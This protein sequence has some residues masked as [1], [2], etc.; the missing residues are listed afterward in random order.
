MGILAVVVATPLPDTGSTALLSF[1]K[2]CIAALLVVLFVIDLKTMLLPDLFV[3]LLSVAALAFIL[4]GYQLPLTRYELINTLGGA[5]LGAGFLLL[6]WGI[7]RGNGVGLGD[8]KLMIPL[9]ALFGMVSTGVLLWLA[10]MVGGVWALFLL[11]TKR[12]QLKTAVPFGPF[13][14]G[15]ALLVLAVP[16]LP[17][18]LITLL[19]GYNPWM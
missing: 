9:G 14:C 10:Y 7:T 19:L 3:G 18:R 11:L 5:A 16:T 13:L 6:I 1:L 2:L 8:V 15:A 17:L 12:A 4:V